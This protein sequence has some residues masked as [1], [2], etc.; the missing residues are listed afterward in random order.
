MKTITAARMSALALALSAAFPLLA[1]TAPGAKLQDTVV[2]ATRVAQPLSDLLADVSIIDRERIELSGAVG[3]ADVL[4]RQ[5]GIEMIRNGGPG[6]STSVSIRGAESRF[7]AIYV[8]GVRVDSQSTGGAMW[9][10]IPLSQIDRIEVL[11][12]PAAAVYGSDAIG[13]VIQLF[14]KKGEPGKPAPYVGVGVGRYGLR[15]A[16]AGISGVADARGAIDYALGIAREESDGFNVQP[17]RLRSRTDGLR[18]PDRDGYESTNLSAR[19]G[20]Q[21]D[22]RHRIEGTFLA[23]NLE[24]QYDA[25]TFIAARPQDDRN[26]HR[27][28][29]GGLN[30]QA[31]WTDSY[32]TK[33]QV[34]ESRS[35]YETTPSAYIT[36]TTLRGYLFQN[37]WRSGPHLATAAL[38]RRED[39]LENPL[40]FNGPIDRTRSQNALALGYGFHTGSHTGSAAYGYAITPQLRA[41]ASVGNAFRAPTL[42]QRFSQYGTATLQPESSRNVEAG[43]RWAEGATSAGI[44]A[45]R[46]KVENLITFASPSQCPGQPNGCYQNVAHAEYSGVTLSGAH[47]LYGVAL[48]GSLDFQDPKDADTGRQLARRSRRHGTLGADTSVAGWTVGAETQFSASRFDNAANTQ[49]LGG[50]A[51]VNLYASTRIARDFTLIA[52]IDNLAD[53]DYQLARTYATPG[54][55][56]Y[57]GVKWAPQ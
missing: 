56:G 42:Y 55:S 13:G 11:R 34:T 30:W 40:E 7:T 17:N 15:K 32:S 51:L 45:Y 9:E 4:A 33:L 50:Y 21:I 24:S 25:G 44:V 5:P 57:L 19:L 46:N 3:V 10:Q 27:L 36:A 1:Q 43:L 28:R 52:R 29:T 26:L 47:T 14:T 37:E 16:E 18:N 38:E 12:G 23:N 49:R 2:T 20:L 8:D 39:R 53:K 54:R 48:R 31:K 35:R 22:P 41:T 6:N